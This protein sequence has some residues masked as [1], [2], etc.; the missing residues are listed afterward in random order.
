MTASQKKQDHPPAAGQPVYAGVDLGATSITVALVTEEGEILT[1]E[2][3]PTEVERGPEAIIDRIAE[4]TRALASG[5][6]SF[7][8][9]LAVGVGSPG[10]LDLKTGTVI[11]T[12]NLKWKN[13]PLRDLLAARL[14]KR[15]IVDN[16]AVSATFGEWWVG[17]GKAFR[18]VVGL[19]LGTGVGGG[20]VLDGRIH[21]GSLGIGGHIGHMVIAAGGR[22]CSCGNQGCLEAYASAT[23]IVSRTEEALQPETASILHQADRPLTARKVFEAAQKGD[24]LAQRIFDETA[25]FLAVGIN[26]ILNVLNPEAII[27]GGAVTNAGD[28]LF[29]PLRQY[30]KNMAFPGVYE[31]TRILRASLGELA[32]VVGAAGIA[33]LG[34]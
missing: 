8:A 2:N 21:H 12:P 15:V 3:F 11:A 19:T 17:A 34:G 23:A 26:S 31:G 9:V 25:W 29:R 14:Q 33:R 16:D 13:V 10:P 6:I 22:R 24:Q 30:V 28:L 5:E 27:L 7:E 20:I 4:R 32:G 18:D 1:W